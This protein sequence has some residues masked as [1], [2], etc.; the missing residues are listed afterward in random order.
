MKAAKVNIEKRI[1]C[2]SEVKLEI[3]LALIAL[4][5]VKK[6]LAANEEFLLPDEPKF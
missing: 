5:N 4:K 6:I 2:F 1:E 3:E